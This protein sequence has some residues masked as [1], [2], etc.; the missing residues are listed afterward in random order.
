MPEVETIVRE[1]K[2]SAK[3]KIIKS[4]ECRFESSCVFEE[5]IKADN[6]KILDV[7]RRGKFIVMILDNN[8]RLVVH[9]RMTGRLMW[10]VE[11][12]RE[13]Y[14]RAVIYFTDGTALYF[15]DVRKFGRV[16]LCGN[17]DF[18]N[19]T[20]VCRLGIEPFASSYDDFERTFFLDRFGRRKRGYLKNNLLRQ[21]LVVGVGNIYAD[22]ICFRSGLHP[23]SRVENIPKNQFKKIYKNVLECL[24]EGILHCGVS[25]SDFVGTNGHL[26]KYQNYLKIYGRAGDQCY[27]CGSEIKKIR[28]AGRGTHVCEKCQVRK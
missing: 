26:G 19:V 6:L 22:E 24:E 23:S 4:V 9:L 15:S 25:V 20:G 11:K 18:E 7:E 27:E 3:N 28:V 14:V 8:L 2:N 16:W 5:G 10:Y 17:K 12:G 13:K 21:D 1:L